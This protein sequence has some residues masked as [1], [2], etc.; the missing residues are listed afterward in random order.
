MTPGRR[1]RRQ[2]AGE[3]GARAIR[4]DV[5]DDASVDA[6]AEAIVRMAQVGPD[7]PIGGYFD[8]EGALPG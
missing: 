5:T 6:A 4:L 7:G 3:P 2:A 8:V 1:K